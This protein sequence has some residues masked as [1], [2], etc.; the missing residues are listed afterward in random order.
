MPPFRPLSSHSTWQTE[1]LP[2]VK[3]LPRYVL[4]P[5][6]YCL[7]LHVMFEAHTLTE[8]ADN[9]FTFLQPMATAQALR[10]TFRIGHLLS[11]DW[12]LGVALKSNKCSSLNAAFVTVF[13][14]TANAN[15]EVS[16][17]SFEMTI[18]EFQVRLSCFIAI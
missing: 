14:K 13:L 16:S 6:L 7:C 3:H 1:R 4:L 12:K 11:L 5:S 8:R 2:S 9:E 18:P 15:N 10:D 17:H